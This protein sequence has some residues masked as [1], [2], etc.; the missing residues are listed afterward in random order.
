LK[1][2]AVAI[3]KRR[4]LERY[5]SPVNPYDVSLSQLLSLVCG[6][7]RAVGANRPIVGE[8]IAESRGHVEDRQLQREY[9]G[10]RQL[11]LGSYGAI[12]V[13]TRRARTVQRL[14]P[15]KIE[16]VRKRM[17]VAGLELADLSAY[18]IARAVVNKSWENPAVQ[19]L[20]PKIRSLI[21]FP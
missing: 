13:Q 10:L 5:L 8:I 12:N 4:L 17:M 18:P 3:H 1:L 11:G 6:P 2:Y 19:I 21:E 20:L 9:Q 16:F 7:P 15:P 14:F